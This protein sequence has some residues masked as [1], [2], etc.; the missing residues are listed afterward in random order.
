MDELIRQAI[1]ER[2]LVAYRYNGQRR[3]GE[4]HLYGLRNGQPTLLVYQTEGTSFAGPYPNWRN[5][6]LSG[7]TRMTITGRSFQ[8]PRL[9]STDSHREW[10]EIWAIVR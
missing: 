6:A 5:C 1:A 9:S 2:R 3:V 4:P 10:S 7:L 8:H